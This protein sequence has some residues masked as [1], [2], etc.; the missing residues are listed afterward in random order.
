MSNFKEKLSNINQKIDEIDSDEEEGREYMEE[1][2]EYISKEVYFKKDTL[3]NPKEKT[4]Y[5]WRTLPIAFF[6]KSKEWN[7][8]EKIYD[9]KQSIDIN[10]DNIKLLNIKKKEI[11]NDKKQ[12]QKQIDEMNIKLNKLMEEFNKPDNTIRE[13]LINCKEQL[14]KEKQKNKKLKKR[15]RNYVIYKIDNNEMPSDDSDDSD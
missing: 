12:Q 14:I 10:R 6:T 5:K 8:M 3:L 15:I 4:L 2:F 11:K 13:E 1:V 7:L 9:Q